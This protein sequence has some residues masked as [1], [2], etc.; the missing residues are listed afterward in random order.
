VAPDLRVVGI[1]PTDHIGIFFPGAERA[2]GVPHGARSD[3][4]VV[5]EGP[6]AS[7]PSCF[8][9]TTRASRKRRLFTQ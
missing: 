5:S 4:G 8:A 7:R 1:V 6:S 3:L 9:S 2:A